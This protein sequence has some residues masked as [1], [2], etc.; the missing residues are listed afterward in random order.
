MKE[1]KFLTE[2]QLV[3]LEEELGRGTAKE[4]TI[5]AEAMKE[6]VDRI[7]VTESILGATRAAL[8]SVL[9]HIVSGEA[10][11]AGSSGYARMVIG[12]YVLMMTGY[13][14][15]WRTTLVCPAVAGP[16]K[17]WNLWVKNEWIP[18]G[19]ACHHAPA[20]LLEMWKESR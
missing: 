10:E 4:Y 5:L 6:F 20:D 16:T 17:I 3:L 8:V 19:C 14:A 12:E 9:G 15:G 11:A 1:W 18:L 2:E 7:R 13:V